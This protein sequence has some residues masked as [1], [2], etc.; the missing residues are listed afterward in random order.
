MIFSK[1]HIEEEKEEVI[2]KIKKPNDE[3]TKRKKKEPPKPWGKKDRYLVL[4]VFLF[5]V[6]LSA[7]LMLSGREWKLP[8]FPR[9]KFPQISLFKEET[10][11]FENTNKASNSADF[12]AKAEKVKSDFGD[13][14]EKL[15]GVYGLYVVDLTSSYSFGLSEKES[16]E[17]ASLIKLPVIATAYREAEKGNLD[18]ETVYILK[19]SDKIAGSG[20]LYYKDAG[21]KLT[22]KELLRLMAN[23]S[24]NTAYGIMKRILGDSKINAVIEDLGMYQTSIKENSTSPSDIGIFF[25]KLWDGD[26][27]SEADKEEILANLTNTTYEEW[28]AAGIPDN[29]RVAHKYGRELHV[30]NDAGIV[31]S[32][33]PF[34]MVILSKGVVERE[35]DEVFPSLSAVVY[36]DLQ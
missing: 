27:V 18:L 26:I 19:D 6:I 21:T 33:K 10:I 16:F 32:S 35:A 13:I 9:V 17:A 14:S 1:K 29:V 34:V 20:S 22:Y 2:R 25:E 8:G 36:Q 24:D 30:V 11:V 3:I 4:F 5:T 23:Q 15:S 12:K 31:F 7:V 28:I